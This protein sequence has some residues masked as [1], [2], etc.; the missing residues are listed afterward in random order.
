[1]LVPVLPITYVLCTELANVLFIFYL[2][3]YFALWFFEK[4][5]TTMYAVL[6]LD[7]NTISD[8]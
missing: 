8:I 4:R 2:V 3:I 1:M 5:A 7:V 6:G